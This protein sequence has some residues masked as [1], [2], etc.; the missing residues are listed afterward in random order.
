M[1]T[2]TLPW[3]LIVALALPAPEA[4]AQATSSHPAAS[5]N[6]P[7][8]GG[9]SASAPSAPSA[10]GSGGKAP[11]RA[12]AKSKATTQHKPPATSVGRNKAP[13]HK[14]PRAPGPPHAPDPSARRSVAGVEAAEEK[15][16]VADTPEL[17]ALRA[18]EREL[19]EP[20][21]E[22][23]SAEV[24]F[25]ISLLPTS[26]TPRVY[27]SGLPPPSVL[28]MDRGL[29]EMRTADW[30]SKLAL[31]DL[32]VRWNDRLVQY[33]EFYKNDPRGRA[34][35]SAWYKKLGAYEP[36]L[37]AILRENKVPEDLL[38]VA[39]VESGLRPTAYSSA[40]AAGL[41][42]F[43]PDSGK[44][45]GLVI[46]RWVDER[47]DPVRSTQAAA[48]YLSDLH[49]R[50]GTW[51]LALAAYNMGFGGLL[52]SIRKY[53]SNDYW[54]L[55][56][57]EAGL[58]WE[59]TLYVPKIL[60]LAVVAR[61]P[62]EFGLDGLQRDP[63]L[64]FDEVDVAPGVSLISIA[65]AAGVALADIEQ[66]NPQILASRVPPRAPDRAA[67]GAWSIRVPPGRSGGVTANLVRVRSREPRVEP[68]V[69]RQG[70]SV[71]DLAKARNTTERVIEQ[72]NAL[73]SDEVP[74]PGTVLVVPVAP[75]TPAPPVSSDKPVVVVA[76]DLPTAPG[77]RRLFYRVVAGD[78]LSG[79]ANALSVRADDLR[80]WNALD[81][82][83]RLHE[84]MT[85][86]AMVPESV[87]RL[88]VATMTVDDVKVLVA[89]SDEFFAYFEGLK[90]RV[91]TTIVVK[92]GDT[93]KTVAR[94]TGLSV[95]MLE[96]INR[97][98][99]TEELRPGERIVVYLPS[100][101][102]A[103]LGASGQPAEDDE[104][105]TPMAPPC[106]DDLPPLP[107][108]PEVG[109]QAPGSETSAPAEEGADPAPTAPAAACARPESG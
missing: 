9:A 90:D 86:L 57:F 55:S 54:Q 24:G 56:R 13:V 72:L 48:K 94:R 58:P 8:G 92:P 34:I 46:D 44:L 2:L 47:L 87:D 102:A 59:T 29:P 82:M 4:W 66:L 76:A 11:A 45:Y 83:A 1:R 65:E 61:N 5:A 31:P 19:F 77:T 93:W 75:T 98:P 36:M 41:W 39:V 81:P 17:A 21:S 64:R 63:P 10:A 68:V 100:R 30:L 78:T 32:P 23:A 109:T 70:E 16:T 101:S 28:G 27:A 50:F 33:L 108:S 103:R 84:G 37:R 6:P 40:G 96:R 106:P 95:S 107:A 89:G 97:R 91:R 38:W 53:N 25:A 51:E 99:R 12:P 60:S 105:R 79:I 85:L 49:R 80:R 104:P 69:L 22:A 7:G 62:V 67:A 88:Q 3:T 52:A 35:A 71:A 26:A 42:Q 14:K 43:M 74:R 15:T 18:A 20:H 73:R